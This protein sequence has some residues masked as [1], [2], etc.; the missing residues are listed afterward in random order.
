MLRLSTKIIYLSCSNTGRIYFPS[1]KRPILF[2]NIETS[3]KLIQAEYAPLDIFHKHSVYEAQCMLQQ[4][5][6]RDLEELLDINPQQDWNDLAYI[7]EKKYSYP[8]SYILSFL[9]YNLHADKIKAQGEL[10]LSGLVLEFSDIYK[11][12]ENNYSCLKIKINNNL[13]NYIKNIN[14]LTSYI[15]KPIKIRLDANKKL[16]LESAKE[17]LSQINLNFINYLE[18][19][20]EYI[21]DL[22]KLY[23]MT[24]VNLALD[25]SCSGKTNWEYLKALKIKYIIIKPSKYLSIYS[26]L[27]LAR[28]AMR[29][30]IK[31]VLSTCFESFLSCRLYA[32]IAYELNLLETHHGIWV[33]NF[34]ETSFY[35]NGRLDLQE[36]LRT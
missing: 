1:G 14:Y 35:T 17:F 11:Y 22:P 24:G 36:L 13:D 12:L 16:S 9:F 33:D 18:E 31:P 25:E 30:N 20:L 8:I 19:P 15:T 4:V 32:L 27:S 5:S 2:V 10:K 23:D 28:E 7:F 26:V 21:Q 6:V 29:H 34:Y 3:N